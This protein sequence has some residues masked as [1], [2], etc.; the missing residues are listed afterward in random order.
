VHDHLEFYKNRNVR[1]RIAEYCGGN[2]L[3]TSTFTTA[4]NLVGYGELSEKGSVIYERFVFSPENH[5]FG[6]ILDK[7]LDIFR[8]V[9]DKENVL[10][11]LDMEYYNLDF[12]GEA[13]LNQE[14]T[15]AKLEPVYESVLKIFYRFNIRPLV[16]MTGQG[17]HFAFQIKQNSRAYKEL[18]ELGQVNES[19]YNDESSGYNHCSREASVS[20]GRAYDGMGR[21]M[22]Y[23]VQLVIKDVRNNTAIPVLC[24]DLAVGRGK[25][26][27]EAVS[28]D[29]SMYGDP[30]YT[31]DIR[32]PFS[33]YQK[34]K[35]EKHK[36]GYRA[37]NEVPIQI[38]LPRMDLSLA[39]ML[40]M[41]RNFSMS[42][43]YA[44]RISTKIPDVSVPYQS[45]IKSYKHSKLY[46]FH[47]YFD[48][49]QPRSIGYSAQDQALVDLSMMP[50]CINHALNH[51]NDH[52][53]KPTNI[54]ALT[55][56]MM[57]LDVHPRRIAE[58]VC[59]KYEE[60]HKW[61]RTWFEYDP[62]TRADFYV[63][64]FGGLIYNGIDN[65]ED[66]N[67]ISHQEK[68]YC[69]KPWCGHNLANYKL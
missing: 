68:G 49:G 11:I 39:D 60:D 29:L 64:L 22:E 34:H 4:N 26:G 19:L 57:K 36:V 33:T 21:L 41:R 42:G 24:T 8:S 54:Q 32:C 14:D 23:I 50:P 53:L 13:Y 30:I 9:W 28:L 25:N 18:E 1:K 47:K 43:E 17:Y 6:W 62:M 2:G 31:R 56:V 66:F 10:G 15:F 20:Q 40:L 3:D 67:C 63:R 12:P 58:M 65:E 45:L 27:R 5:S 59:A 55:R 61:G 48:K 51:P 46:Q 35:V 38:S 7:G 44:R 52:L 69:W 37:A 16:I